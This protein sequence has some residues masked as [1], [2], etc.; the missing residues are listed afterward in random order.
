M[1]APLITL[2]LSAR[3]D[4]AARSLLA[5]NTSADNIASR[6]AERIAKSS[7]V[8]RVEAQGCSVSKNGGCK[9]VNGVMSEDYSGVCGG[10]SGCGKTNGSCSDFTCG[11]CFDCDQSSNCFAKDVTTVC[12]L[13]SPAAECETVLM[14]DL[15][16]GD[17]VLGRDGATYVLAVQHKAVDT[18]AQMLTLHTADGMSVSVTPDHGIFLDG[19]L[20]AASEANVG[21]RLT[22]ARGEATAIQRITKGEAA[23][24]NAI[25]SDGTIVADGVLAASNPYWIAKYAVDAPL[26]RMILNVAFFAAGDT[27]SVAAACAVAAAQAAATFALAAL[28][29]KAV[30]TRK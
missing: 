12:L 9:C 19:S 6:V 17:R 21:A 28:A 13:A 16:V 29:A 5:T 26:A 3:L 7:F 23:I 20:V 8:K 4:D 24:I 15:A 2:V 22:N 1:L 27:D 30:H 18:V 14:A 11:N 10:C 25:T